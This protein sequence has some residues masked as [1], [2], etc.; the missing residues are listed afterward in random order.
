MKKGSN[1]IPTLLFIVFLFLLDRFFFLPG[2]MDGTWE[3][4]TGVNAGDYITFDNIDIVSNYEIKVS[5][6]RTFDSF[7]LVG[8]YFGTLYLLDKDSLEFTKYIK[9]EKS[10]E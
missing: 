4:E 2:R 7:Y 3:Y 5:S 10:H 9:M 6:N 8:C 1:I